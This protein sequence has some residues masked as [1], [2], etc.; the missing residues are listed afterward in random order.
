MLDVIG[1][2]V[3]EG[4]GKCLLLLV[5]RDERLLFSVLEGCVCGASVLW[6]KGRGRLLAKEEYYTDL[7]VGAT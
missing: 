4:L 3:D 5:R 2:D 7:R 1:F 6:F